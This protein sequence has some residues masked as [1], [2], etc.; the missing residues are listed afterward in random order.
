MRVLRT[1]L[2]SLILA[3]AGIAVLAFATDG[4][5]AFTTETARRIAVRTHP[6][7]LPDVELEDSAGR[8][9][10]LASMR[11]RWLAVDFIYT[12]CMTYCTIL[13]G[14][15]AQ[16]QRSMAAPLRQGHLTLLS[17]S[18][19]PAHDDP[20][21]LADYQRRFVDHGVGWIA[22][23]PLDAPGLA[24][25]KSAFVLKAIPDG[26]GGYVHNTAIALVDPDGRIVD[27]LDAGDAQAAARVLRSRL[28]Q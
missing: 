27:Y 25:L 7:A 15:F 4:F 13:G 19:D 23:R 10:A 9:F 2:A 14:D 6:V 5:R 20:A 28:A 22:A 16:L 3:S 1:L 8:L 21:A 18:F 24:R 17:I 12:R 26:L 11:G